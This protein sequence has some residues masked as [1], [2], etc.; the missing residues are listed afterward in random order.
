VYSSSVTYGGGNVAL[1]DE[2]RHLQSHCGRRDVTG[3]RREGDLYVNVAGVRHE[4][5]L[6]VNAVTCVALINTGKTV[7]VEEENLHASN[8][9]QTTLPVR[10]ESIWDV[11]DSSPWITHGTVR[12]C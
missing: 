3:V 9:F 10:E 11:P 8:T 7:R 12:L 1:I 2:Y 4:G 5:D 6:Y